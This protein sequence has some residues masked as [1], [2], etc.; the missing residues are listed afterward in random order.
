MYRLASFSLLYFEQGVKGKKNP[1]GKRKAAVFL[2]KRGRLGKGTSC[3]RLKKV[4]FPSKGRETV[5]RKHYT[6]CAI[7]KTGLKSGGTKGPCS[8]IELGILKGGVGKGA[9]GL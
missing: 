6:D 2:R 4:S 7:S 1:D 5:S 8:T 9:A 3:L